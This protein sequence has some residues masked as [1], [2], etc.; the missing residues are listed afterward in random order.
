M[1]VIRVPPDVNVSMVQQRLIENYLNETFDLFS[2]RTT[3][4]HM[5]IYRYTR[6]RSDE[7]GGYILLIVA[8][9]VMQCSPDSH[10]CIASGNSY[11]RPHVYK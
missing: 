7:D 11:S 5:H 8:W 4:T 3:H 1:N 10:N 6:S 2:G 9:V